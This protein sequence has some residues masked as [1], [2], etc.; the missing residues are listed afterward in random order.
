MWLVKEY[1]HGDSC[2]TRKRM[3]AAFLSE[4]GSG[5]FAEYSV[6]ERTPLFNS[7]LK[8]PHVP[9]PGIRGKASSVS[10]GYDLMGVPT[11]GQ[12]DDKMRETIVGYP[13]GR[14]RSGG[15]TPEKH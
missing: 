5:F 2:L 9:W 14:S 10:F 3:V 4:F 15:S 7:S 8:V 6:F 12:T 1:G 13:D 11:R